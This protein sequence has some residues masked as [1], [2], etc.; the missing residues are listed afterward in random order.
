LISLPIPDDF[1]V[2]DIKF[3]LAIAPVAGVLQ[4]CGRELGCGAVN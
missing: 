2:V 1:G 4:E 3:R